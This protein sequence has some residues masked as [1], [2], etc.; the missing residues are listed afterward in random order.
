VQANQ[1]TT[2]DFALEQEAAALEEM[3]VVGYGTQQKKDV[4]G[5]IG[6]IE[7]AEETEDMTLT[8]T[9]QLLQGRVPGLNAGVATELEG[10]TDLEVRG[11]TSIQAGNDP[12]IVVDGTRYQG[13]L[14][15]LNPNSI[16][17][18][19]VL[20]GASAAAVY[21]ASAAAGVIEVTTKTGTRPEPT[22][23]FKSS[24]GI[25]VKGRL[26]R[27]YGPEEYIQYIQDAQ[28]RLRD[29]RPEFYFS[30]PRDLPSDITLEEWKA[31]GSSGGDEP[32]QMF[33]SRLGFST[34]EI[35]NYM[36]GK[37]IDWYD[38]VYRDAPLRQNYN[39]S[40]S[41]NPE[42]VSYYVSMG[43]VQNE[44]E[45]VGEQ[46]NIAR[47]RLNVSTNPTD[48]L[49]V[50][51][52][53][54]Y[55]NRDEGYLTPNVGEAEQASPYGDMFTE[56]GSLKRNPH[57]APTVTNPFFSSTY[58]T[59]RDY[60]SRINDLVASLNADLD[61]PLGFEY[62]L[63]YSNR[64]NFH[65]I[66]NFIPSSVPAGEPSGASARTEQTEHRWQIDNILTW[67]QMLGD[68]HE[69]Q[70]TFLFNVE[71]ENVWTTTSSNSQ[72]PLETLGYGALSLGGTPGVDSDDSRS[73]G[74]ALMGRLNYQ[75]L[76]RYLFTL[77]YRRDG[78]S[79]FGQK[80]PYAYFPSVAFGWRISEEP[81]FNVDPISNL[82]LRLSWGKNGN[83]GIGTYAALQRLTTT[84]YLYGTETVVGLSSSNLP[85]SNLK[86]EVT[87]QYNAGVDFELMGGRF[88]G[89]VN[90]Y[91][92]SSENLL[93]RRR[94][95]NIT[96]YSSVWSNL[97]E[98]VNRGLEVSLNS[99]NM[100]GETFSWN[101]SLNFSL[102]RNEIKA[103]YGTGE[104]DRQNDWFIGHSLNAIYDYEIL[105][106]WKQDEAEQ[107]AVYGRE[108]GDFKL[109][110]V[111]G[112]DVL[113]P[114]EDKVFQGHTEPRYRISLSND[115]EYRNFTVSTLL[116]SQL[117]Q[118]AAH[119]VHMHSSYGQGQMNQPAYPYWTPENPTSEWARIS[120]E[121]ENPSFNYWELT[122]FVRLQNL[123]IDYQLPES[124]VGQLGAKSLSVF[125]NAQNVGVLTPFDGEDP[126]VGHHTPRVF[127]GG[128]N[129]SF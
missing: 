14:S 25:G 43:Y 46:F 5:S 118:Y 17:S 13:S 29:D 110:D 10:S 126:E 89:S 84:K 8:S 26:A 106:I 68:I 56:D 80:H 85:N 53:S 15:N 52:K 87:T 3:V 122:S 119:N 32:V 16:E 114:V 9:A 22:I 12:L 37:T 125:F 124:I 127:S 83:R 91:Y 96:G 94:L 2:V 115:L 24:V 34:G 50:G 86:W 57:G 72:F 38:R 47:A 61:L 49:E 101:S 62:Q 98:V 42:S 113:T 48:W 73:T 21:G 93:L 35:R 51:L 11:Q 23:N 121:A 95:P 27:P 39:I 40:V 59:E 108:P 20:K 103:L 41:G 66:Y 6:S 45:F 69:F 1:T 92:M 64:F 105:G 60:K 55:T 78:Y 33:L 7:A 74:T 128:V 67:D 54:N 70:T 76:S 129:M 4:T 18:I 71:A 116:T 63:Q 97:G 75:L 120:S 109:R 31:L 123:S 102:N 99:L 65:Q 36:E 28:R 58:N 104:D 19:D 90:A 79:A 107:A 88:S 44:G 112:D 82:K 111:N 77:S 81:F 117:G 30:D 100:Q